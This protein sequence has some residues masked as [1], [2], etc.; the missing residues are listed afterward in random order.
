MCDLSPNRFI[1][2]DALIVTSHVKLPV[3]HL[4]TFHCFCKIYDHCHHITSFGSNNYVVYSVQYTCIV[5]SGTMRL[6]HIW[7]VQN[8]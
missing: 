6:L 4:H 5:R 3:K 8:G 7:F 2:T 1:F